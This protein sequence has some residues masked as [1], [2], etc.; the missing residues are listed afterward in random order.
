[1]RKV[2]GRKPANSRGRSFSITTRCEAIWH[3]QRCTR[4]NEKCV[5]G[6]SPLC[7]R[8][9][10]PPTVRLA[11]P[12]NE[13][14]RNTSGCPSRSIVISIA[15][16]CRTAAVAPWRLPRGKDPAGVCRGQRGDLGGGGVARRGEASDHLGDERRLGAGAA[17]GR[18]GVGGRG[19]GSEAA[20]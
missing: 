7:R 10:T 15:R 2:C 14:R 12:V 1:M 6:S 3:C 4:S 13:L 19:G 17:V 8:W 16:Q 11:D 18:R 9:S 5:P 20:G